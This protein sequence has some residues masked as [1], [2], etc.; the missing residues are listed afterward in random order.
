MSCNH[1]QKV[2]LG[3]V[4]GIIPGFAFKGSEF[5]DAGKYVVKIK[6]INSP[7]VELTEAQKVPITQ[8]DELKLRKYILSRGD[9]VIAMT[10]ATIGKIGIYNNDDIAYINQR[11]A[12]FEPHNNVCKQF[13]LY[14]ISGISFQQF[15]RNNIDSN[16]A[17][18][19]ISGTSIGR[20]EFLL[21][22]LSHQE[23]IA[24]ILG[25]L[26]DKIELNNR[27]NRNLEE[28]AAALFRRWFIDF[29][30]PDSNG[31]PYR[32]SGGAFTDSPLG[33]IPIG[34]RV[35]KLGNYCRVKSGYAF[36]SSWW[37]DKGVKVIKIKN[38]N[39]NN[40]LNLDDC[41]FVAEDKINVA[42]DFKVIDGDLLIAM[43][44]ATI[45]KFAIV[46]S[47]NE[48]LL[49]NQRV[50]KFFL[51]DN[52]NKKLPFIY[53]ILK[54]DKVSD[55]IINKGQGSAQPNISP[56]DIESIEMAYPDT[57]LIDLYNEKCFHI[58]KLI[59]DNQKENRTLAELRDTLLPKLMS[60]QIKL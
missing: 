52:P 12:K 44:G 16:S 60:N 9:F 5:G 46:C 43:T 37:L 41:S 21:P 6:D 25:A 22:P 49:V 42:K 17:Q 19:N 29:E 13:I 3:D 27:I 2:R 50:G 33:K 56:N 35:G 40:T 57:D 58:F 28:Q 1:W 30:F 59:I 36:K 32:T 4:C 47:N 34:W 55:A 7:Y 45:G 51:G 20:F 10:G 18:E 48:P 14:A 39:S 23:R 53:N 15:I 26:D 38:I 8:Q 24:G 54:Q 31:N 11:V